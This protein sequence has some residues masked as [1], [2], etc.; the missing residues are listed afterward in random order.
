MKIW[1][2]INGYIFELYSQ[3]G[4]RG[5]DLSKYLRLEE[6][7]VVGRKKI[8]EGLWKIC[9]EIFTRCWTLNIS[10]GLNEHLGRLYFF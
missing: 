5:W 10:L 1:E 9:P 8:L 7:S 2:A 3:G 4:A 6:V